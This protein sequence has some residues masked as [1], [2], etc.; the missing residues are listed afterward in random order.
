MYRLKTCQDP[1]NGPTYHKIEDIGRRET[2]KFMMPR[3]NSIA[4]LVGDPLSPKSS[5]FDRFGSVCGAD[6]YIYGIL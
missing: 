4:V 3:T 6:R 5:S 1:H 2:V